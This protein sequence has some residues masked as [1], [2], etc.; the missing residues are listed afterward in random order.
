MLVLTRTP[1]VQAGLLREQILHCQ[2]AVDH[3]RPQLVL[4]W[5]LQHRGDRSKLFHYSSRSGQTEGSGVSLSGI[6][7][8]DG[9]LRIPAV[10]LSSEGTYVCSVYVPPLY[11]THNVVLQVMGEAAGQGWGTHM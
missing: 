1:S 7:K 9:S 3:G 4:E 5:V 6:G 2:F 10:T 8:G 11:A